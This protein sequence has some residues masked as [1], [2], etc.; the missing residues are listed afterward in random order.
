LP[1]SPYFIQPAY[2]LVDARLTIG[3]DNQKWNV[4]LWGE[5]L[6]NRTYAQAYFNPA[7]QAPSVD[8]FLGAPRTFGVTLHL[9]L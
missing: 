9:A 1:P 5:N 7:L 8:A 4:E 6:T 2:T 3:G